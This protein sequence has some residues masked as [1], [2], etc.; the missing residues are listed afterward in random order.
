MTAIV[1]LSEACG[2]SVNTTDEPALAWYSKNVPHDTIEVDGISYELV[3]SNYQ[4]HS[5]DCEM[6]YLEAPII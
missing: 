1:T 4:E 2:I 5:S 6:N 3:G